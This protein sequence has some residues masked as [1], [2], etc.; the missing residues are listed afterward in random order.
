[1]RSG[2]GR[3]DFFTRTFQVAVPKRRHSKARKNK[4]RAHD[5]IN[6]PGLATCVRCGQRKIPHT[7]CENCGYY[8]GVSI[9]DKEGA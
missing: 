7:V 1:M 5:A 8:R 9:I 2:F 4:R 6:A 3:M